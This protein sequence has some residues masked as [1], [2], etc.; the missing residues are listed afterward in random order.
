[1]P[2]RDSSELEPIARGDDPPAPRRALRR[3][4][5]WGLALALAATGVVAG[6]VARR[7]PPAPS[8]DLPLPAF[9][10]TTEQNAP[11]SRDTLHGKVWIADFIFT[12]CPSVCPRLTKKMASIQDRTRDLGDQLHLV[13]FTVDPEND[14]PDK[15]A[16]YARKYGADPAR[17]SFVTGPLSTIEPTVV[18]GFKIMM[19]KTDPGNGL[20]SIFHGEKLVLVDPEGSIRGYFD[21]DEAGLDAVEHAAR[22]LVKR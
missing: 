16:A 20:V 19:G 9:S 12:T 18:G 22:A 15:L 5:L 21:A 3:P 4:A 13:S 7:P 1:M 14:T 6:A 11:F 2:T 10:L 8:I 17:W